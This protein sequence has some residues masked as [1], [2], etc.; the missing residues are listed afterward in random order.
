M[1]PKSALHPVKSFG[2]DKLFLDFVIRILPNFPVRI[3]ELGKA[4]LP[5]NF[6]GHRR[7]VMNC[8]KDV[9]GP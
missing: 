1:E 4:T 8:Q 5:T 6:K 7:T 2:C 3:L 9:C